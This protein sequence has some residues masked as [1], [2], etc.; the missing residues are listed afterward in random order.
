MKVL[1]AELVGDKAVVTIQGNV[2]DRV[3]DLRALAI[4]ALPRQNIALNTE[5]MSGHKYVTTFTYDLVGVGSL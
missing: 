2:N 1:N 4:S 3:R 5:R